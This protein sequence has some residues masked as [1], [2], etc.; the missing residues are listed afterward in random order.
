[1]LAILSFIPILTTL[2]LMTIF[3]WSAKRSLLIAWVLACILAFGVWD[4]DTKSLIAASLYGLL[5]SMDVLI[6]ITGAVL[7]M[8]TLK[9][10]GA[11]DAINRGFMNINP[12]KRV[13]AV[14]FDEL[15][16]TILVSVTSKQLEHRV[17]PAYNHVY[18]KFLFYMEQSVL[19]HAMYK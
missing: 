17:I 19:F 4:I 14:M 2:I 3:N 15:C 1:M 7:V 13:Q 12:D 11:M 8:N 18:R 5:S 16:L 9:S 6:I 10:S